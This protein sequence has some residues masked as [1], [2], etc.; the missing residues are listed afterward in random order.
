MT[1]EEYNGKIY[2]MLNIF[3][4]AHGYGKLWISY[5]MVEALKHI[6]QDA[7]LCFEACVWSIHKNK[8]YKA[9]VG[10]VSDY[11]YIRSYTHTDWYRF[12]MLNLQKACCLVYGQY[13]IVDY[14]D[15]KKLFDQMLI[16]NKQME[17]FIFPKMSVVVLSV[18][19]F[20]LLYFLGQPLYRKAAEIHVVKPCGFK[21]IC[22][23]E[24]CAD[25]AE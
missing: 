11:K 20:F 17:R 21:H 2:A 8:K 14:N 3:N 5:P 4:D 18:F 19:P 10:K 12:I 22:N 16:L 13:K 9:F 15:A 25:L 7:C 6:K 24:V 23:G 1:Q